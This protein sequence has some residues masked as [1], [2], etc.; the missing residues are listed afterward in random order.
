M[1]APF[2][3]DYNNLYVGTLDAQHNIGRVST[4]NYSTMANWQ[5]NGYDGASVSTDVPFVSATDLH[6]PPSTVNP[7]RRAG[8]PIP[9]YSTDIDGQQRSALTPDIGADE[10]SATTDVERIDNTVP[11]NFTVQQNYPNPFNPSTNISFSIVGTND[12]S[13]KIQDVLGRE[14]ATLVNQTLTQGTYSVKW[15]ATS[16]PSGVY[17]YTVRAGNALET[18]RMILTK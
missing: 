16:F 6:V 2:I 13:L 10:F 9:G 3:S 15:D 1:T 4:T 14:V 8:T 5:A 12:V 17:F 11:K 18:R 7:I